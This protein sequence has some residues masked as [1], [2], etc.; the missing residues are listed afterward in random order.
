VFIAHRM[1]VVDHE[2]QSIRLTLTYPSFG[3]WLTKEIVLANLAVVKHIWLGSKSITPTMA[4]VKASQKTD[5]GKVIYANSITLT[6]GTV[7]LGLVGDQIM[8][9]A[10]IRE[11][12]VALESGDMDR[13]VTKLENS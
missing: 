9:H 13:R 1:D 12:I 7:A 11:N 2:S 3:F 6:P 10:L 8:V 5:V 4:T